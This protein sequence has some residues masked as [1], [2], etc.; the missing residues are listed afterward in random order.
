MSQALNFKP[1]VLSQQQQIETIRRLYGNLHYV[2][3]F[4]SLFV[5]QEDEQYEICLKEDAFLVRNGAEGE[6]AY[7]FPCGSDSGKKALIEALLLCDKPVFYCVTDEDKQFLEEAFP[8]QFRFEERREEFSYLY[9]KDTQIELPGKDYKRI[10][11]QI[12]IGQSRA[13][14]WSV[15]P[16][17]D[18]NI[19]RALAV[20]RRWAALKGHEGLSDA[21]AAETALLHFKELSLWG[22]LFQA[23]GEDTA[24]IAGIFVSPEV[25]DFSFCKVLG[26]RCDCFVK[27]SAYRAL[28]QEIKTIDSEEDLGLA[29]LREHKLFRQPKELRRIWKGSFIL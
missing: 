15:E 2:Y 14:E 9:D 27:W 18:G 23:D 24:Y 6:H 10:R 26:E 4:A 3:T 29:G 21:N 11:H 16:I 12:H 17:G 5:W 1:I 7:L 28:P 22:L 13:Q 19:D 8:N 25:F 20:N